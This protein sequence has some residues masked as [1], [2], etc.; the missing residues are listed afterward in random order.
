MSASCWSRTRRARTARTRSA[1]SSSKARSRR[2][3]KSC[4]ARASASRNRAAPTEA[5]AR[6]GRRQRDRWSRRK[7]RSTET[8]SRR[9]ARPPAFCLLVAGPDQRLGGHDIFP[10][11][12]QGR[13]A[14]QRVA[15]FD[16]L[17]NA[18]AERGVV[19]AGQQA[20]DGQAV[21]RFCRHAEPRHYR[22]LLRY[23]TPCPPAFS[24][25]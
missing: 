24:V 1:S 2:S 8:K 25:R 12:R 20:I 7:R 3:R 4:P 14:V 9:V 22:A 23:L 15:E 6:R 5:A 11:E 19:L 18:L 16:G 13:R 21:W 10:V 17:G